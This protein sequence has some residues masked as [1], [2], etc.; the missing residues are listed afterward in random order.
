MRYLCIF[1]RLR[2]FSLL[3]RGIVCAMLHTLQ[4]YNHNVYLLQ[5]LLLLSLWWKNT[6]TR[7]N[8]KNKRKC[9]KLCCQLLYCSS[10]A[11]TKVISIS[12]SIFSMFFWS[13]SSSSS[14]FIS[15][16]SIPI[17]RCFCLSHKTVNFPFALDFAVFSV[18]LCWFVSIFSL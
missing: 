14:L 9:M 4:L 3:L 7:K 13:P 6:H 11:K 5:R 10:C 12:I 17:P 18:V 16:D 2:F 8:N 15:C 1:M